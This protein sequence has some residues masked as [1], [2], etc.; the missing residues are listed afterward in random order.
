MLQLPGDPARLILGPQASAEALANFR[1]DAGLDQPVIVQYVGF[2]GRLARMDFGKSHALRRSVA[3][4][5]RERGAVSAALAGVA[6]G[7]AMVAGL[8]VPLIFR[9]RRW[10]RAL[11]AARVLANMTAFVPPYVLATGM[12]L[13]LAGALRWMPVLFDPHSVLAWVAPA[14]VLAAYPAALTLQL[15]DARL[16][17]ESAASYCV[18]ARAAGLPESHVLW[19]EAAPNAVPA[20]LAALANGLASF[21]T[22]A[23]FVEAVFGLPGLGR[24]TQDALRTQDVSVLAGVCVVVAAFVVCLALALRGAQAAFD[25]RF[26]TNET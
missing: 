3:G 2:M 15:F 9:W 12:L 20:A 25:P 7:V 4:L 1:H 8:G 17:A 10:P 22:G 26:R 21:V 19:R 6:L 13:L 23:L 16:A 24:L 18:R 14:L 5:L 11:A